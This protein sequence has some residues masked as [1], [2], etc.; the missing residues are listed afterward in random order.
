MNNVLDLLSPDNDSNYFRVKQATKI[1]YILC[2]W[3]GCADLSYPSSKLRR[4]RVQKDGQ[5]SP[6]VLTGSGIFRIERGK[7]MSE[8]PEDWAIRKLTPNECFRLMAFNDDD[9]TRCKAIGTSDTQLYKCA[10]NSIITNCIEL[11]AEHLYKAQ[12]DNNYKCYDENF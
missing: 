3:G 11:I 5:V 6:T 12:V 1:G 4:G 10:G 2:E 7:D 8:R 9:V